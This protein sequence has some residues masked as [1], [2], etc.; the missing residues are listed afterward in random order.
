M[1]PLVTCA[2]ASILRSPALFQHSDGRLFAVNAHL[3]PGQLFRTGDGRVFTL[4]DK[5]QERQRDA[6][7]LLSEPRVSPVQQTRVEPRVPAQVTHQVHSLPFQIVTNRA[8]GNQPTVDNQQVRAQDKQQLI[9]QDSNQL[10][11]LKTDIPSNLLS[12]ASV[13][14]FFS[15]PSAGFDYNLNLN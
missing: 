7:L 4:V 14:Q 13:S 12:S 11:T 2:P 6:R 15:F 9:A 10:Q 1:V 3:K 5:I 8:D